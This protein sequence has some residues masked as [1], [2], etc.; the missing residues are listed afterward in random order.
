MR[1]HLCGCAVRRPHR[2]SAFAFV[3]GEG[4]R[5]LRFQ[6]LSTVRQRPRNAAGGRA[7]G[8]NREPGVVTP[9]TVVKRALVLRAG[10]S[11]AEAAERLQTEFV[12]AEHIPEDTLGSLLRRRERR[13]R[14][15]NH[16]KGD[17]S[18]NS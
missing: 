1:L 16:R 17:P 8:D 18:A 10:P 9:S 6:G 3:A 4:R 5:E 12:E 7:G 14:S 2:G 11:V 15:V 13:R